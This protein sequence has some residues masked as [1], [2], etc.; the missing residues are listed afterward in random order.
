MGRMLWMIYIGAGVS[1][2]WLITAKWWQRVV[3][4]V[5][6]PVVMVYAA[7]VE[8]VEWWNSHGYYQ[9]G[10]EEPPQ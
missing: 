9:E 10:Q 6:W 2:A 1:I 8:M 3:T 5:I 4:A 7:M